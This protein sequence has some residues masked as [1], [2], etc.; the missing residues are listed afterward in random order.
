VDRLSCHPERS[1]GAERQTQSK[2]LL[3][4]HKYN[5]LL[6]HYTSDPLSNH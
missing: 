2:D 4:N 3:L 1:F 6:R 5:E